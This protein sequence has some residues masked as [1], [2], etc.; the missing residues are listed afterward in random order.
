MS[1]ATTAAT[2]TKNT[3]RAGRSSN[4]RTARP[5]IADAKDLRL[6]GLTRLDPDYVDATRGNRSGFATFNLEVGDATYRAITWAIKVDAEIAGQTIEYDGI[7]YIRVQSLHDYLKTVQIVP[8][9]KRLQWR[10]QSELNMRNNFKGISFGP[11]YAGF[12]FPGEFTYQSPTLTDAFSLGTKGLRSL[13]FEA[14]LKEAFD[15]DTMELVVMPYTVDRVKPIGFTFGNERLNTTFVGTGTHTYYDLPVGD[16][17][18]ELMIVAEGISRVM[19]EIDGDVLYDM[20]RAAYEGFL[21]SNGKNPEELNGNW[22]LDI[23]AE[24]DPR[25]VAGLDRKSER[26]RGARF[27]LEVTCTA[28]TTPVEFV[29]T[30]ADLYEKIR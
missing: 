6:T 10:T 1:T 7:H 28:A 14:E 13:A 16:D 22:L 15:E 8:N 24:R 26:N 20:D 21:I 11:V 12:A 30:N 29:V 18:C 4:I 27:K 19:L 3:R 23:H 9:G 2:A 25:S 17:L 5:K